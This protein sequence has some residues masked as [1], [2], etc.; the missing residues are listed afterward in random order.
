M[1][2][3]GW[4][5][6]NS[7]LFLI[8][9]NRLRANRFCQA[10]VVMTRMGMRCVGSAPGVTVLDEQLP[11][12]QEGQQPGVQDV[13]LFGGHGAVLFPP[14]D[15]VGAGGFIDNELILGGAPG[16]GPGAHHHRSQVGDEA[17]LAG[18]DLLVEGGCGEVPM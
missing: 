14:G 5:S 8:C 17:F 18:D 7:S 2:N 15:M 13:E 11:P 9:T 12:L 10:W 1:V 3:S 4:C 16:V 6:S